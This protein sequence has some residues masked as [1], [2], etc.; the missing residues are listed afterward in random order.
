MVMSS[1]GGTHAVLVAAC[2]MK[3]KAILIHVDT[4]FDLIG[5]HTRLQVE[6]YVR[7]IGKTSR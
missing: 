2:A 1:Y 7:K 5:K 6:S 4:H 3:T